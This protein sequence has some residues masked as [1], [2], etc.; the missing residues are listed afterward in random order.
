MTRKEKS[1]GH[2]T[3]TPDVSHIRNVE[4]THEKSDI[5][6]LGVLW[7]VVAL[8]IG[9]IAVAI[10]MWLLFGYFERQQAKEKGPGPMALKP[11]ER[12]PPEPR[13]Q[14]APGFAVT[15][16]D[17]KRI[18]LAKGAPQAEYE[19]LRQQWKENLETGL[20]DSSGK[21]VG[22]SI[23]EAIK[24]SGVGRRLAY[25]RKGRVNQTRGPRD[26]HADRGKFRQG[27]GE[28]S[29]QMKDSVCFYL[30][31]LWMVLLLCYLFCVCTR[32]AG[33]ELAALWRAS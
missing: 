16:E 19:A 1:N 9:T 4:V 33:T 7:F 23:N 3:E 24:K 6:V 30:C 11:D 32:T 25:E 21:V 31:N 27:N 17:G 8:T 15:L 12:L 14:A 18:D 10:A 2:K 26:Q 13:L 20:K 22:I 28:E 5:N 29:M